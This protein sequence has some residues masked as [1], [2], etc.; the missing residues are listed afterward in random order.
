MV[1]QNASG[2]G[3]NP[4]VRFDFL[5]QIGQCGVRFAVSLLG[6]IGI[7]DVFPAVLELLESTAAAFWRNG[8][9]KSYH[10]MSVPGR[11]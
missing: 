9:R 6:K 7:F 2:G 11:G 5:R 10:Q 8:R 1:L 4:A 3:T